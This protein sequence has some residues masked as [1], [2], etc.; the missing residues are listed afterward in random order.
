[1][2]LAFGLSIAPKDQKLHD[3]RCFVWEKYVEDRLEAGQ[4]LEALALIRRATKDV[5]GEKEWQSESSWFSRFGEKR[6]KKLG[7]EAGLEVA[8]RGLKAL[9]EAE[10]K[11]LREWRGS[12]FRQ[13]SQSLLDKKDAAGSLKVLARAY[14]LDDADKEIHAGIGYHT[15]EAL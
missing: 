4:D 15:Q 14:A 3:N 13:W 5:P 10:G 8:D 9:P 12:V 6:I 1:G 2:V 7:W 11:K